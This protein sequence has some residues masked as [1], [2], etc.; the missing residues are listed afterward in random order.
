MSSFSYS[1]T[2]GE[3]DLIVRFFE[4]NMPGLHNAAKLFVRKVTYI[5]Q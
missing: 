2:A 1:I 4:L 3:I 5:L